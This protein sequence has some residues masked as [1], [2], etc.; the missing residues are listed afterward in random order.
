MQKGFFQN[1][2]S[3]LS[4]LYHGYGI[5]YNLNVYFSLNGMR[6]QIYRSAELLLYTPF[7]FLL[8]D[9]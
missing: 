2:P 9:Y 6:N 8:Q 7:G 3:N 4:F 5:I 1:E